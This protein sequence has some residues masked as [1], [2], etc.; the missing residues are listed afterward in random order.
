M[1]DWERRQY[2]NAS[3]KEQEAQTQIAREAL[4]RQIQAQREQE[5]HQEQLRIDRYEKEMRDKIA[6]LELTLAKTTDPEQRRNIEELLDKAKWEQAAY[7]DEKARREEERKR[8]YELYRQ[9]QAKQEK[10][11]RIKRVIV[12]TFSIIILT[13]V[14]FLL[15]GAY[16]S[17]SESRAQTNNPWKNSSST[18]SQQ[19]TSTEEST[20]EEVTSSSSSLA[21]SRRVDN[22]PS[23]SANTDSS[24]ENATELSEATIDHAS[25]NTKNLTK[26]QLRKWVAASYTRKANP[27]ARYFPY[28]MEITTGSDG[29]AYATIKVPNNLQVYRVSSQGNLEYRYERQNDAG[30]MLVTWAV[31]ATEY[32]EE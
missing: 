22:S 19:T 3:R 4:D 28:E 24:L 17:W 25:V 32:F 14:L 11:D 20:S 15:Y 18:T 5:R 16:E 10:R 27:N 9:E 29:L 21:Q 31:V 8:Q 6:N 12:R 23:A 2:L 7:F 1:E 13:F 30:E 26:E